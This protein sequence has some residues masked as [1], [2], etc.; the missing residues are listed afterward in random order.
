MENFF[1]FKTIFFFIFIFFSE[2]YPS[3][4]KANQIEPAQKRMLTLK[5]LLHQLPDNHFETFRHLALHLRKVAD[6]SSINKV[7]YV[8]VVFFLPLYHPSSISKEV[9]LNTWQLLLYYFFH[10]VK[11]SNHWSRSFCCY[12][13]I[14]SRSILRPSP[15]LFW[16]SYYPSK[17]CLGHWYNF[18]AKTLFW[19]IHSSAFL[20][21]AN[22]PSIISRRF[23]VILRIV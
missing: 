18:L 23:I 6:H 10:S 17:I 14:F 7:Q 21:C 4:I 12:H 8:F 20:K 13:N 19:L 22:M 16:R 2:L 15:L 5:R 1:Q 9:T 11:L 3:F